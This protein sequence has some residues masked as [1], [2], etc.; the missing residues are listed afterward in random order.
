ME[1]GVTPRPPSRLGSGPEWW[2]RGIEGAIDALGGVSG[3]EVETQ[4]AYLY[5][6]LTTTLAYGVPNHRHSPEI[7]QELTTAAGEQVTLTFTP[8][9]I[10]MTRGILATSYASLKTPVTPQDITAHYESFYANAPFVRVCPPSRFPS[11]QEVRGT[12]MYHRTRWTTTR[13]G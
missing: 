2:F 11:I 6:E 13:T 12:N 4:V 1:S 7:E 3:R 10:P 5:S 9:L 8:H